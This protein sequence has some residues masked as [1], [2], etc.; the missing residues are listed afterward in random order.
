MKAKNRQ[1]YVDRWTS[2]INELIYPF[3]DAEVP[4]SEFEQ[5]KADLLK[6]IE[7]AADE[8]KSLGLHS[9]DGG[10]S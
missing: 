6:V 4:C 8:L 1:D 2:H 9:D 7:K 10:Q 5:T 3:L